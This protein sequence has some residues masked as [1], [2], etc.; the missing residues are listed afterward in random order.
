MQPDPLDDEDMWFSRI[1]GHD[2][3][4]LVNT[5]DWRL[6]PE[7]RSDRLSAMSR[8]LSWCRT[9]DLLTR[10]EHLAL[11]EE[12]LRHP[13]LAGREHQAVLAWRETLYDVLTTASP[14]AAQRVTARYQEA[15]GRA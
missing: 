3:L 14:T 10:E 8:V 5:V 4:D 12:S 13:R 11:A 6:D 15:L 9:A 2:G 1:G 7:R